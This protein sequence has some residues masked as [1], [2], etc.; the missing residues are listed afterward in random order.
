MNLTWD[1]R[2]SNRWFLSAN[3]TLSRLW[4]NYPGIQNSDEIRTPTTNS[5]Y[6]TDQQQGRK[7]VPRWW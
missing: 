4:G 3:Y 2:F 7:L 1:R 6:A 5:S